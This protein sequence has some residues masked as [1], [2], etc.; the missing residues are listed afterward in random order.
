V[1]RREG[2][3]PE[4]LAALRRPAQI[5]TT[6]VLTYVMSVLV[7]LTA[8]LVAWRYLMGRMLGLTYGWRELRLYQ[9]ALGWA[10]VYPLTNWVLVGL[11]VLLGALTTGIALIVGIPLLLITLLGV[12]SVLLF[13]RWSSRRLNVLPARAFWAY[14]LVALTANV[15]YFGFAVVY[16]ARLGVAWGLGTGW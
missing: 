12:V 7:A 16:A 13:V 14:V 11:T 6:Q 3:S 8:W 10:L 15:L 1:T 2:L 4:R 5:R 9:H